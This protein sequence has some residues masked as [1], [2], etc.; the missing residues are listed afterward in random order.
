[1]PDG[2]LMMPA[3]VMPDF[4]RAAR[5]AIDGID[6]IQADGLIRANDHRNRESRRHTRRIGLYAGLLARRLGL[7][8]EQVARIEHAAP[9]HD[10]GKLGVPR[11]VID[12]PGPL[13]AEEM[14]LMQRHTVIGHRMLSWSSHPTLRLAA[15]IALNHHERWDGTGYPHRL[16]GGAIPLPSRIVAVADTY[17]A[18]RMERSYKAKLSHAEALAI[19]TEGDGRTRPEHFDRRVLTAFHGIQDSIRAVYQTHAD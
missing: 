16:A 1:M 7:P 17:D 4:R 14:A 9:L 18:L 19:L 13:N 10:I 11:A 8:D 12:K 6:A 2:A 5:W 15:A 3:A